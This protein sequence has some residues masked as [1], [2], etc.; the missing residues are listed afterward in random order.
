MS[1]LP[2]GLLQ[3]VLDRLGSLN[4]REPHA[5]LPSQLTYL[6][7]DLASAAPPRETFETEDMIWALWCDHVD[8][9][10]AH[11]ME[12]ATRA[13][14]AKRLEAAE[15][16]LNRL[17]EDDP[18]WAEAW[19][20]RATVYFIREDDAAAVTDIAQAIDLE[21]RHFGALCGLGMICERQDEPEAAR[22]AYKCALKAHPG[23]EAIR[24][25]LEMLEAQQG[26]SN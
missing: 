21:P 25:R 10:L 13:M 24:H 16:Y 18:T 19:N 20:K 14:A 11:Q 9:A 7:R 12:L 26:H 17:I 5:N 6:F 15:T 3:R 1:R 23:L 2:T 8:P 4:K 22:F